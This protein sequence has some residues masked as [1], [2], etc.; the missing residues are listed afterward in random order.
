MKLKQ[1]TTWILWHVC[2]YKTYDNLDI[3]LK[4]KLRHKPICFTKIKM[5]KDS[6]KLKAHNTNTRTPN[7]DGSRRLM[8]FESVN[9]IETQ[10][11][12]WNSIK[13]W[14]KLRSIRNWE[15]KSEGMKRKLSWTIACS[16]YQMIEIDFGSLLDLELHIEWSIEEAAEVMK[17][18][19]NS[20]IGW[21]GLEEKGD[22]HRLDEVV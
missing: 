11:E 20:Q 21:S 15:K 17:A 6:R 10:S 3:D 19:Y 9:W 14:K 13:T 2:N 12:Q 1:S 18:V 16:W 5:N 4:T 22:V 7:L 8:Q